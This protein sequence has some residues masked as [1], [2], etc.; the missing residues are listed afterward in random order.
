[1]KNFNI[2]FIKQNIKGYKKY[3]S[4]STMRNALEV[5]RLNS[6]GS[7][8]TNIYISYGVSVAVCIEDDSIAF[9]FIIKEEHGMFVV[10]EMTMD[11]Y[12]KYELCVTK[13]IDLN[14]AK[15]ISNDNEV[16][17]LVYELLKGETVEV[18]Y[19]QTCG[20]SEKHSTLIRYE[21]FNNCI[22][23]L[24]KMGYVIKCES[25]THGN[26]Y[27]TNNGGF[28]NSNNYILLK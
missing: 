8:Y 25:N 17:E 20:K 27:A 13:E 6:R 16:N 21:L 3:V 5:I 22:K 7:E 18:G 10:Y 23:K 14:D 4:H 15:C 12:N 19:R 28:W 1:M 2:E 24:S 9:D 26:A 11:T